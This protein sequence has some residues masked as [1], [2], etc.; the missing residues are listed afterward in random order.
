MKE[1]ELRESGMQV[2]VQVFQK[3]AKAIP[4]MTKEPRTR[5]QTLALQA[6]KLPQVQVQV[7]PQY[8]K[9]IPMMT[10]AHLT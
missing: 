8:A 9:A 1:S 10:R 2:Q 3:H 6:Q 7:F 4:M 5:V